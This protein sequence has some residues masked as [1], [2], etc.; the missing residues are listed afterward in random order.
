MTE[1]TEA[2][3]LAKVDMLAANETNNHHKTTD[4]IL[5]R[6]YIIIGM[7]VALA[8]L[9]GCFVYDYAQVRVEMKALRET[10][11]KAHRIMWVSDN[12]GEINLK[13]GRPVG[14]MGIVGRTIGLIKSH[15]FNWDWP[16][17][18]PINPGNTF[19][20]FAEQSDHPFAKELKKHLDNPKAHWKQGQGRDKNQKMNKNSNKAND[21]T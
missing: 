15:L 18:H 14:P 4:R 9:L 16:F 11:T 17:Q 19:R 12:I 2:A 6:C 13:T 1:R 5:Y 3:L 20:D 21:E 7:L 10:Q 8:I